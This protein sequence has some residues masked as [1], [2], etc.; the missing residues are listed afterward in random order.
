M[1]P[2]NLQTRFPYPPCKGGPGGIPVCLRFSTT[3]KYR[4]TSFLRL[5]ARLRAPFVGGPVFVSSFLYRISLPSRV[6]F[7]IR[8]RIQTSSRMAISNPLSPPPDPLPPIGDTISF[9]SK[10]NHHKPATRQ[11][12]KMGRGPTR[13]N[14]EKSAFSAFIRVPIL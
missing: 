13:N 1:I 11:F 2:P 12:Q 9:R 7:R 8:F 14:K 3:L 6:S 4:L 5:S 10:M